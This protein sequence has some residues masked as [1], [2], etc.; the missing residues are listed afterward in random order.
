MEGSSQFKELFHQIDIVHNLLD[1]N[2][3]DEEKIIYEFR[4]SQALMRSQLSKYIEDGM[5][6]T[7]FR[8]WNDFLWIFILF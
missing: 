2:I 1:D 4:L 3:L 5:S 6:S 7:Q 8:Y